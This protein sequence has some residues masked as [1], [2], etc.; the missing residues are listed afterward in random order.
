MREGVREGVME[1]GEWLREKGSRQVLKNSWSMSGE[2]FSNLPILSLQMDHE[3]QA[4]ARMRNQFHIIH[5][6]KPYST[7]C[8]IVTFICMYTLLLCIFQDYDSKVGKLN[9]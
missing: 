3:G 8:I 9:L 5:T 4:T 7:F 1:V 6:F 2:M